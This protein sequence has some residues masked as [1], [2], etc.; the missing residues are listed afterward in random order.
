M[1]P[2]TQHYVLPLLLAALA[3]MASA[4]RI[5]RPPP[6][7]AELARRAVNDAMNDGSLQPGDIIVTAKGFV[8]FR[9]VK[10]NGEFEFEAIND[11]LSTAE[12]PASA[13]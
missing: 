12:R 9:G 1:M 2:S 10:D 3:S 13:K 7:E 6:N 4:Q 8:R 11:P 5:K